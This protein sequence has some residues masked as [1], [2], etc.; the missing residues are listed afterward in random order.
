M[1]RLL[2]VGLAVVAVLAVIDLSRAADPSTLWHIVDGQCVP[3][4]EQ[5]Q[6]PAPCIKVDLSHGRARGHVVLKDINGV[7]QFL[8]MPTARINGMES[9]EILAADAPNYW[10]PAWE[11]R[12]YV[13]DRL[14]HKLVRE[15]VALAINS[16]VGRTQDQ[17][18]IHVDCV[19]ADVKA[20]LARQL[21]A[22]GTS[23]AK[24]P[25]R[26]AGHSYRAMRLEQASLAGA[27]P[28]HLLADSDP[29]VA[30]DMAYHTLVVVGATFGGNVPGFVLLD[31]RADLSIGDRASGEELQDH[32]CAV[33]TV[34]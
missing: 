6:D 33:A 13:E 27:D 20:A 23:W 10:E 4:Q 19:R 30:A 11:A 3:H 26:L 22:I 8:V 31:D 7:A 17:L 34:Q 24:L 1:F 14:R 9:A 32:T 29:A 21:P 25:V 16:S 5:A 12:S 15:D 28:F 2:L 18:H